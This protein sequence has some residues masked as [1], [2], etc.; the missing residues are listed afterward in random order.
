M[1]TGQDPARRAG[2]VAETR[3]FLERV[4][5]AGREREQAALQVEE[6]FHLG[7]SG[8]YTTQPV[9]ASVEE[10]LSHDLSPA[11]TAVAGLRASDQTY[12]HCVDMSVIFHDSCVDILRGN[13]PTL[14]EKVSRSTL[15][16]GF[17][18]DIGKSRVP[19]EILD[20]NQRYAPDS[21]EMR[22]IRLH[23]EHGAKILSD[24]GMDQAMINVAHY[25]HVK[26]DTSLPNSYPDVSYDKVA[27]LTRLAAVVDVYQALIGKRSYKK[28]WV[29]GNAV[30]YL[31]RLKGSEFDDYMIDHFLKVI[32]KYPVGSLVRLSTND[33]AFVTK[34]EDQDLDRPVVAVVENAKGEMLSQHLLIDL[35]REQDVSI[36]EIV[37]HYEHFNEDEDHAFRVFSS[38]NVV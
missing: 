16:A 29:P 3:A 1:V 37:D 25:H 14:P 6:M 19:K 24:A 23:A 33:L 38:L 30:E 12:T 20:S 21:E 5:R 32:G 17:M 28:N 22:L 9:M 7:R 4:N 34:T 18:H 11:M 36:A 27:P 2:Q 35:D 31:A 15:A 13:H 26:K 10:I 8:H